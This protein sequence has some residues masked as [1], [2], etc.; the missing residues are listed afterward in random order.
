[1]AANTALDK[2][3]EG[4]PYLHIGENTYTL[5]YGWGGLPYVAD[6]LTAETVSTRKWMWVVS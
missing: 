2:G 1:M 4:L 6:P 3:W 5:D